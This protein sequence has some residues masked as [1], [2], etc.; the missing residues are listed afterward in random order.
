VK[1]AT[2]KAK[3]LK[4]LADMMKDA[5]VTVP[6]PT[7]PDVNMTRITGPSASHEA[8]AFLEF[9]RNPKAFLVKLCKREECQQP[10]SANS[11]NVGYCSDNCRARQ[12]KKIGI[13][14]NPAK[15]QEERWGGQIPLTVSP[16]LLL[17]L[18]DT[19][20]E[21]APRFVQ[22]VERDSLVNVPDQTTAPGQLEQPDPFA[23]R[24]ED[25]VADSE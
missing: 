10:F 7:L 23:F 15:S 12:L 20:R 25:F 21:L 14:W 4:K 18:F 1:D 5:G 3:A 9:T 22:N 11:K 8:E 13:D 16:Q 17:L 24:E 19:M 2:R 6:P